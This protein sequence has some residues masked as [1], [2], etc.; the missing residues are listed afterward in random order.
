ME[1]RPVKPDLRTGLKPLRVEAIKKKRERLGECRLRR[2][3]VG[4][5]IFS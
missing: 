4:G 5:K 2:L 1:E 3:E